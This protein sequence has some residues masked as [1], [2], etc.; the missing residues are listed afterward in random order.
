MKNQSRDKYPIL[1]LVVNYAI[2]ILE[3]HGAAVSTL[4]IER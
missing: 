4:E 1:Y 3:W 2:L